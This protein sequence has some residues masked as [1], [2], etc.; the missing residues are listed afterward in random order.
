MKNTTLLGFL[1][2]MVLLGA[3]LPA[4][5]GSTP[6]PAPETAAPEPP[7]ATPEPTSTAEPCIPSGSQAQINAALR[8][9]GSAAILCQGAV[10]DLTA[11]VVINAEDQQIYT[12]GLPTDERRA[13]LRIV[14]PGLA[15]A[16]IMRD[17]DNA[18]LSHLIVDGNRPTLGH[19]GGDALIYAGGSSSGQI[20]RNLKIIEP[21]S[22]SA[23]HL[24]QGH[25]SPAPPCSNALIENNEIG[26]AG[27]S[28]ETWADGISLACTNSIVRNNIIIDATD[29]GIVIFGAPG[30]T[31]EGNTIR[32]ETRTLLGGIN[33]VDFDPYEGNYTGTVVKNNVIDAS[34][35]VIRIGLGMGIRVWG[36]WPVGTEK[37]LYGASVTGNTLRGTK[38]QY[39]FAVD[40]VRD[41]TATGNLDEATHVG[42][43][44]VDCGGVVASAPGGFQFNPNRAQGNFQPEFQPARLELTLW[45]IVS[46]RPGE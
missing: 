43:P 3:C 45:A 11:P 39:G 2:C 37:T 15:T 22:W 13:I 23:L 10:F 33:M 29:G 19:R 31:I 46:P 41:W 40:G 12:Q 6:T 34:G 36:C 16:I 32:A 18:T 28:N 42:V 7:T 20:I 9:P 26:P 24:I 44:S 8:G 25:P 17:Y 4:P 1:L 27:S 14:S 21:R 35:A 30:S 38:M 5:V